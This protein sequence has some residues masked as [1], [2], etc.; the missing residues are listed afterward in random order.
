[1]WVCECVYV[2]ETV[3][4]GNIVKRCVAWL[5]AGNLVSPIREAP[6]GADVL[7]RMIIVSEL[8]CR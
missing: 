1:M 8:W 2:C 6:S 3:I 5:R 4:L 7:I